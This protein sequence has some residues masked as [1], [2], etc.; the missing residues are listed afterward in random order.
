MG[1]FLGG[2]DLFPPKRGN[3]WTFVKFFSPNVRN[4][5]VRGPFMAIN[6]FRQTRGESGVVKG[7]FF[8]SSNKGNANVRGPV[9]EI[10]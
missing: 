3:C 5:N 7:I 8:F 10:N 9:L 2:F 1:K 6:S 4:T